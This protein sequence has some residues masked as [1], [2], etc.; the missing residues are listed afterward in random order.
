[1]NF[2]HLPGL[3]FHRQPSKHSVPRTTRDPSRLWRTVLV[4]LTVLLASVPTGAEIQDYQVAHNNDDAEENVSTGVMN[5]SSSDLE[6]ISDG[7]TAQLVGIRFRALRI[8]AGTTITSAVLE[9]ETDETDSGT[10]SLTI[11]GQDV[12]DAGIFTATNSNISSRTTTTASTSWSPGAWN[13]VS[14]RHQ[15]A[16]VSAIVQEIVDRAGWSSGNDMV[17]VITGSGERTAESFN[18]ESDNAPILRVEWD[19]QMSVPGGEVCYGVADTSNRFVLI[20]TSDGSIDSNVGDT[21]V[22]SIEA[23]AI[24]P[25]DYALYAADGDQL[26]RINTDTGEFIRL[27]ETFGTGGGSA[28]DITFDDVDSLAFDTSDG[29]FYGVDARGGSDALFEIDPATGAHVPD[30]FGSGTDYVLITGTGI[31][32]SIDDIAID[33]DDG[34]IYGSDTTNSQLITIDPSDGSATAVGG[35]GST[36]DMEGLG[37]RFDGE[38]YGTAGQRLYTLNTSTGAATQ[39][40]SGDTLT[41]GDDYESFDCHFTS[42]SRAVITEVAKVWHDGSPWVRWRTSAEEGTLGFYLHRWDPARADWSPVT[43]APVPA[44]LGEPRG[45]TYW[46]RDGHADPTAADLYALIEVESGDR[47]RNHGPF[48]ADFVDAEGPARFL[49]VDSDSAAEAHPRPDR[50]A[51][52]RVAEDRVADDRVAKHIRPSALPTPDVGAARLATT[53]AGVHRV[54]LDALVEVLGRPVAELRSLLERQRLRL[55]H[56]GAAVPWWPAPTGDAL[57]FVASEVDDPLAPANAYRLDVAPGQVM[58][59]Y[60]V[61]TLD[62][63][64]LPIQTFDAEAVFERDVFAGLAGQPD[65]DGDYWFWLGF[66]AGHPVAGSHGTT[67]EL[68]EAVAS[69]NPGTVTAEVFGISDVGPHHLELVVGGRSLGERRFEGRGGHRLEWP[70]PQDVVRQ[71]SNA[72]EWIAHLD[73][74]APY[75][76][77]YLDH[78]R[79]TYHRAARSTD[80]TSLE[81]VTQPQGPSRL[82]GFAEPSVLVFDV[83]DEAAPVVLWDGR[84]AAMAQGDGSYSLTVQGPAGAR[85]ALAVTPSGAYSPAITPWRSA[86]PA[87]DSFRRA[88]DYLVVAPADLAEVAQEFADYRQAGGLAA[89]VVVWETLVDELGD[90]IASPAVV[91]EFLEVATES[92]SVAPRY[93]LL[94]GRGTFDHRDHLGVG[95]QRLPPWLAPGPGGLFPAPGRFVPEGSDVALGRLPVTTAAEA[96]RYLDKLIATESSARADGRGLILV[97]QPAPGARFEDD[98]RRLAETAAGVASL[99]TVTVGGDGM[100]LVSL[101]E[102]LAQGLDWLTFVGHGSSSAWGTSSFLDQGLVES[103]IVS[104][105]PVVLAAT[106]LTNRSDVPGFPALGESWVLSEGGAIAVV[107]PTGT[108]AHSDAVLFFEHFWNDLGEH[109]PARLGDALVAAWQALGESGGTSAPQHRL[110]LLGDPAFELR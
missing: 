1:M 69:G 6:M 10:T 29:T 91:R 32:T 8:P 83:A 16:D 13:T 64:G 105:P 80:G 21:D 79:V 33:P 92:W 61:D 47:L 108:V 30:A 49:R 59:Q 5:R 94:L 71:G 12:D 74:S 50:V 37:F 99:Q 97:D 103:L 106:C 41:V 58:A 14:E 72:F 45:G 19:G 75:S 31:G 18:G 48:R 53:E 85:R 65:P 54:P 102:G 81:L 98:A 100:A 9:F 22:S 26:G 23:I 11:E 86:V 73:A 25:D 67:F 87:L 90:G 82:D 24:D 93:V 109:S 89:E 55:L 52:D 76:F 28:G 44:L 38:L 70:L 7:G 96:R 2:P 40:G 46:Q 84:R 63:T 68:P 4:L 39:V 35:F 42:T 60:Q 43:E 15:S 20:D 77:F 101:G 107:G 3:P 110:A 34:T 62:P 66:A 51:E 36:L 104:R 95:D 56:R 88:A 57:Y 27:T 78:A 17:F